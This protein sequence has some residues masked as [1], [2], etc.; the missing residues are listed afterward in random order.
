[1]K[2][3][4]L[5]VAK[6]KHRGHPVPINAELFLIGS[7]KECQLQSQ[8][9][10]TGDR[11][12]A[13]LVRENKVFVRDLGSGRPT[14]V[15]GEMVPP[16]EEWPLHKGDRLEAGPFEFMLQFQE[17]ALSQRDLEEWALRSLDQNVER[18]RNKEGFDE[19]QLNQYTRRIT[20]ASEAAAVILEHLNARRGEVKGRLRIAQEGNITIVRVNDA[21]L[22][23]EAE[24]ALIRKELYDNC[25]RPNLRVLLDLKQ[26]RRMSSLAV[27]MVD[28]LY[29]WLRPSGSALALCRIRQEVWALMKDLTLRNKI[30]VF[31]DKSSALTGRW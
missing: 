9:P 14:L 10:G 25:G 28:E 31:P 1:V 23:E 18:E 30:P 24:I 12:C 13:L 29:T 17:R 8:L 7:S 19:D 3:V 2:K 4:Y 5:I 22:V 11:H 16:G 6:G 15:N 27:L 26:V 21:Y 20:Q